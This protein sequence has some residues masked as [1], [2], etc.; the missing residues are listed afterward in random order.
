MRSPPRMFVSPF[1]FSRIFAKTVGLT[2]GRYLTALR[3][4]EAKRLLLSTSLTVS[5]VVC[6]VGY[7]SVARS[8]T[9]SPR[10]SA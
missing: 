2:P 5:D 7:S 9:G 3:L 4:F 10:P 8:P 6:S 1:H